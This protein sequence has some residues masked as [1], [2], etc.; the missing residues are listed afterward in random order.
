MSLFNEYGLLV[1][2]ALPAAVVVGMQVALFL[3]GER[4]TGL[5]PGFDRYP[6]IKLGGTGAGAAQE[7]V[8]AE[9]AGIATAVEASNDE[10][11]RLAA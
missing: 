2:V 9:A 4:G 5:L 6:S 10:M 1:A 8:V 3:A 11:D 7:P